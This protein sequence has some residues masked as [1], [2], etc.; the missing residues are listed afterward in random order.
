MAEPKTLLDQTRIDSDEWPR[1]PKF[2]KFADFLGLPAAKDSKGVYWRGD[3]KLAHKMEQV[4][5]WAKEKI[6]SDDPIDI[7]YA[8]NQLR[9]EL[10][11]NWKGKT[12]VDHLWGYTQLDTK[13]VIIEKD[14]E[15]ID[16]EMEM[17]KEPPEPERE[18]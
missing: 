16:K 18:E 7:M 5:A 10:G 6:Q 8:V 4:W 12:L 11:V 17:Y 2:Q 1:S 14:R 15:K 3:A 9:K 13:K